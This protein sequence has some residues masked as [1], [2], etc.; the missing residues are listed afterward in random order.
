[1]K[2]FFVGYLAALATLAIFDA[3]W[4]GLASREFYKGRLGQLLLDYA[5]YDLTNLATPVGWPLAVSL[6]D[7]G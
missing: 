2:T 6:V 5:A 4:V 3:P 1:M 7:L